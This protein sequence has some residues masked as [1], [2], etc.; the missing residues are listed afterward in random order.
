[1]AVATDE[2]RRRAA[3]NLK[4][5]F[6]SRRPILAAL[7]SAS[8][9]APLAAQTPRPP[10]FSG[11]WVWVES[12]VSGAGRSGETPAGGARTPVHTSSG[13][14]FN[15]G[16]ECTIAHKGATLTIDNAQLADYKGKDPSERTPPVMF[17]IDGR[18]AEVVDSFNPSRKLSATAKWDG[19]KLQITSGSRSSSFPWTQ[20]LS[21]EEGH[22]M[23]V[24]TA[25]PNGEPVRITMKY[26]KK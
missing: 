2:P 18:E 20:I 11:N 15:C 4:G 14:A 23:V 24:H 26:R 5:R 6:M 19:N 8:L 21:L 3:R 9:V 22:L 25:T 12:R 10:N 1:M 13:A 16:R 7:I 17:R